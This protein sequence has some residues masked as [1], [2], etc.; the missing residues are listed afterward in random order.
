[1][2]LTRARR[3]GLRALATGP[4]PIARRSNE[5]VVEL[6]YVYWQSADWLLAQG[7]AELLPGSGGQYVQLTPA[8]ARLAR[9]EGLV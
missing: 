2:K 1:M 8:G 4:D 9:D 7:L 3:E 5:T 6:Q